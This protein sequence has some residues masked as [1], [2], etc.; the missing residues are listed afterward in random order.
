MMRRIVQRAWAHA[1]AGKQCQAPWGA[2]GQGWA[3]AIACVVAYV[4]S[5]DASIYATQRLRVPRA[6][7]IG[8]DP[9]PVDPAI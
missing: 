1:R 7:P 6:D 3:A 4:F 5:S 2:L 9:A 8:D